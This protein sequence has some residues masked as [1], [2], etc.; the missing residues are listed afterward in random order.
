M[1]ER[2]MGM[3]THAE[4]DIFPLRRIDCF[5]DRDCVL[6]LITPSK[7]LQSTDISVTDDD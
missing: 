5:N 6:E 3:L 7:Q 4:A 1:V 2:Q